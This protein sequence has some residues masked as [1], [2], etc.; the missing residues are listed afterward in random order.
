VAQLLQP[1]AFTKEANMSA[2]AI[3]LLPQ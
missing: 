2:L 1:A 3:T